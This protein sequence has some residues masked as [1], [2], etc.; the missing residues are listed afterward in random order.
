MRNMPEAHRQALIV[1]LGEDCL[2]PFGLD[3]AKE[4]ISE[5]SF[6]CC[7]REPGGREFGGDKGTLRHEMPPETPRASLR[8]LGRCLDSDPE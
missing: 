8:W 4:V 3:E 2:R 7:C 5:F 1:A 6:V